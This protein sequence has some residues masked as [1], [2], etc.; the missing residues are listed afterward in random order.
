MFDNTEI[1]QCLKCG[2]LKKPIFLLVL[3]KKDII[4]Y[5]IKCSSL[6]E[7]KK[8]FIKEYK[9]YNTD[10]VPS[11]N[12]NHIISINNETELYSTISN[13]CDTCLRQILQESKLISK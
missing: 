8:V 1:V 7:L 3:Y 11:F 2:A 4:K 6:K 5:I 12:I 10:K 9:K 13:C